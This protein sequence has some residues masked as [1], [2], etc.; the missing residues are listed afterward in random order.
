[1]GHWRI[2]TRKHLMH[3]KR[4]VEE[5]IKWKL[6]SGNFW[7]R[8]DNWLE[9]LRA[10]ELEHAYAT[11]STLANILSTKLYISWTSGPSYLEGE[12]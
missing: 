10:M 1:M 9:F 3:N 11:S 7:L 6:N 5:H 8:W 2:M 4:K 12:Q